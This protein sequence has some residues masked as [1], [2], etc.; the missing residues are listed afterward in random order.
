M[1]GNA[2]IVLGNGFSIDLVQKMGKNEEIDLVNLF[3]KGEHV[4]YPKT[5]NRGFL[6]RKYTPDLWN[7]GARTYMSY[8]T[9]M[10]LV[11][12]VITC[13][14]VYNL[15]IE[16]RPNEERDSSNIYIYTHIANYLHI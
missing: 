6:S 3:S 7:L 13:A 5:N 8:D 4:L 1:M 16:K 15:S 2:Y 9:A 10:Q 14:N 11:T 12:D